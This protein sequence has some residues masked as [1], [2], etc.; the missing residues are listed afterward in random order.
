VQEYVQKFVRLLR[1]WQEE[2]KEEGNE[3]KIV[4]SMSVSQVSAF[5]S[6]VSLTEWGMDV[7]DLPTTKRTTELA[8]KGGHRDTLAWLLSRGVPLE[9]NIG[10]WDP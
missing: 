8:V 7:L 5:L 2:K 3:P 6:S 10:R 9:R 1:G 4:C